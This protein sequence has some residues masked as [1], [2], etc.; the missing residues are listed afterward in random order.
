[1]KQKKR[2]NLRAL[3]IQKTA[4]KHGLS[5]RGVRMIVDGDRE[6]EDVFR[7]Y[8]ELFEE[9]DTALLRNMVREFKKL[10]PFN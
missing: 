1:M 3:A 7:D 2:D 9:L 8:M 6:N 10:V 5:R 4:E